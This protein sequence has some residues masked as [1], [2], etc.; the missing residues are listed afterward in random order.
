MNA[1]FQCVAEESSLISAVFFSLL[2]AL[3]RLQR[4]EFPLFFAVC[5]G[6]CCVCCNCCFLWGEACIL[7]LNLTFLGEV[8]C[9]MNFGAFGLE[10]FGACGLE[11]FLLLLPVYVGR[12]AWAGHPPKECFDAHS[13]IDWRL[14]RSGLL[15]W[16]TDLLIRS[17]VHSC[18]EASFSNAISTFILT[19]FCFLQILRVLRS[20]SNLRCWSFFSDS[21]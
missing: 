6:F 12:D 7:K 15:F 13:L 16:L 21:W 20:S 8:V 2:L 4:L 18:R 19:A 11:D 17:F 9:R 5:F 3:P 14:A 1:R 10:D